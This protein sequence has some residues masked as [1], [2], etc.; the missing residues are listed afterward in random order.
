VTIRAG[1]PWGGAGTLPEG[2]VVV[3]SDAAASA[4]LEAAR[5]ERQ[6]FP[7]LGLLGGDLC[8]TV[9]G[10]GD[11]SRLR[12][13]PATVVPVD[14][15]EVLLDG[16]LQ[17][18]VAHVVVRGRTWWRGPVTAVMNA[19][20]LGRWDVAPRAHPND[21]LID[22]V[23][24]PAAMGAGERWKVWRRLPAGAHVP[25]PAIQVRRAAAFQLDADGRH[26]WIDG[27]DR[28]PARSLSVRVEPD[29]LTCAV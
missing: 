27:V 21:G 24:V 2:G 28:G 6:P 26:V 3:E 22:L 25:H 20:F 13:G 15:G 12:D 5:R 9:G 1:E 7:A 10:R 19:Q 16:R 23:E 4:A 29:A 17:L 18:F 14:L 11:E 8:R